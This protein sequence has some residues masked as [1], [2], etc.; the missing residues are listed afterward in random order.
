[1]N[2]SKF[3]DW[4]KSVT[5]LNDEAGKIIHDRDELYKIVADEVRECFSKMDLYPENIHITPS[6]DRIEVEFMAKDDVIIDPVRLNE[7][8]MNF[9][10]NY[11]YDDRGNWRVILIFYPFKFN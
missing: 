3:E 10:V 8:H 7:L 6:A 5:Q 9:R 4:K 1:M 2:Q 11:G